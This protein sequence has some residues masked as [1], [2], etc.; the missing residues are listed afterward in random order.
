MKRLHGDLSNTARSAV[1]PTAASSGGVL[2]SATVRHNGADVTGPTKSLAP[3]NAV[4]LLTPA[5]ATARDDRVRIH[6]YGHVSHTD[7]AD[8]SSLGRL[9]A[10]QTSSA[11]RTI[12]SSAVSSSAMASDANHGLTAAAPFATPL[13]AGELVNLD[14]TTC[15]V[16]CSDLCNGYTYVCSRTA[17]QL[18]RTASALDIP[19][20]GN[21]A[22]FC[23]FTNNFCCL[24][25]VWVEFQRYSI[26]TSSDAAN[27][28]TRATGPRC[29]AHSIIPPGK[30]P[31]D[32]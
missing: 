12:A 19:V 3:Q 13:L 30:A 22:C 18:K 16:Y 32:V 10:A 9:A 24:C 23:R 11:Y 4:S 1:P 21:C 31:G 28:R 2:S 7:A 5:R 17:E 20:L 25:A 27:E 29:A 15:V 6:D 14:V 8:T 26:C